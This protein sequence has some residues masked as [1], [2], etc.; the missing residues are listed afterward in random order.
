MARNPGLRLP[1]EDA[2]WPAVTVNLGPKTVC[3]THRDMRNKPGAQCGVV[4]AGPFDWKRGGH[5]VLHEA[6]KVVEMRPGRMVLFPSATVAHENI[7]IGK[8]EARYSMTMHAASGLFDKLMR[9]R[10]GDRWERECEA[11]MTL[12]EIAS[13]W[14]VGRPVFTGLL[15]ADEALP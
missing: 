7:P 15:H 4:S 2:L 13:Y 6:R 1:Y 9:E 11:F 5:L 12:P 10:G 8:S 14:E 3:W